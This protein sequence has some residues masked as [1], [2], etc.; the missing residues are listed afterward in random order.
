MTLTACSPCDCIPGNEIKQTYQQNI[1][2]TLCEILTAAESGSGVFTPDI[3]H[4]KN[5]TVSASSQSVDITSTEPQVRIV[6]TSA[7]AV[8][9]KMGLSSG[10]ALS[11]AFTDG[12]G[13]IIPAGG[14]EVFTRPDMA[15]RFAVIGLVANGYVQVTPGTGF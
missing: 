10:G 13:L 14:V 8:A 7:S 11:A 9:V 15:D 12:N 2:K 3:A 6:N 4:A 1:R 5:V